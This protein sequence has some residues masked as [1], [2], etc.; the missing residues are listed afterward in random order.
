MITCVL[1]QVF[2]NVFFSKMHAWNLLVSGSEF[3]FNSVF[4]EMFSSPCFWCLCCG[5][6]VSCLLLDMQNS[7][8]VLQ[9]FKGTLLPNHYIERSLV[10]TA[11][12]CR[13]WNPVHGALVHLWFPIQVKSVLQFWGKHLCKP[14]SMLLFSFLFV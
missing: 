9:M 14:M 10:W 13:C 11:L 12:L 7:Y 4:L 5:V 6:L 8:V 2:T 3:L 1:S